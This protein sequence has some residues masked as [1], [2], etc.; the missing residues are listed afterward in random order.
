[1]P[2]IV[3]NLSN[4]YDVEN[5]SRSAPQEGLIPVPARS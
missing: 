3:I 1:M 2:F 4:A 5:N